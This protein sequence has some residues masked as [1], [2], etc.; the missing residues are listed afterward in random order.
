MFDGVSQAY[1]KG[2]IRWTSAAIRFSWWVVAVSA[3]L[4]LCAAAYLSQNIRIN[5]DTGGMLSSDLDFQR[6]SEELSQAFPQFSNNLVVVIDGA[7]PDAAA[8]ASLVLAMHLRKSPKKYG[9]VIDYAGSDFFRRNGFL[10]MDIDEIY[11]LSDRL[12]E[13]QPFLGALWADSSLV[14]FLGV[15]GLA[16]DE[17]LKEENAQPIEIATILDAVNGVAQAQVKGEWG[18]MSWQKLMS[19]PVNE[20]DKVKSRRRIL[21]I[22]PALK[23]SSLAPAADAMKNVRKLAIDLGLTQKNGVRV[24][25]TG[26]AALSQEELE[27]VEE[28]MGLAGVVSLILVIGLLS[29]GLCSWRLV[30]AMLVTLLM[31]LIW[32]AGF[33]IMALGTL[34]LI[35]VAFA[36]LFIGLSVDFGIHY[37]LRYNE[38]IEAGRS[39]D[40][41]LIEAAANVGGALTLC[42]ISA[43]IAFYSFLLTDYRGLAELGLIAGTGMFIALL[44]NVTLLPALLTVLPR[45]RVSI[46]GGFLFDFSAVLPFIRSHSRIICLTGL[47]AGGAAVWTLPQAVFDFDPMNLRDP[48]KESVSTISDLMADRHTNPYSVTIL[49]HNLDQARSLAVKINGLDLVDGVST[50]ADYV[51]AE[52]LE[53][54][55]V[56]SSMALFLSPSFARA[57]EANRHTLDDSKTSLAKFRVKLNALAQRFGERPEGRAADRLSQTLVRMFTLNGG[58]AGSV[59]EDFEAR[60][61]RALPGR[62]FALNQA[63]KAEAVTLNNLP[64]EIRDNQI[65]TD[66]RAKLEVFAKED[67]RDQDALARF[68]AAV[69]TISPRASGS[70]VTILEAGNTVIRAIWEA[71]IISVT[72]IFMILLVV[73]KRLSSAILVLIPLA[74]A[75]VLTVAASTV[76][77][78]S[79][80]FAN[81]IVLPLLFGIGAAGG[82]HLVMRQREKGGEALETSTPRAILFSALTTI[83]S[84][85]SIALS[86]HPGTSSMGLLLTISIIFSLCCTLVVLPALM[87]VAGHVSSDND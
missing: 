79:F 36:V 14:G 83:G 17:T 29:I 28:G 27:S 30:T 3:L 40:D 32:T 19:G 65:A 84:F 10:Y 35:S 58:D 44:A 60:L 39:N 23:F 1:R 25:L 2:L 81:V 62:L 26:S 24:R 52:Q 80:N 21:L 87:V 85:G 50:L 22:Q 57:A 8:D 71:G 72:L 13:A 69:R 41:A 49:A 70:S 59:I 43:A 75:A 73:L 53:K 78:L 82:I 12:A 9:R 7:T 67:L 34:N 11:R 77:G 61:L 56:I 64:A 38:G 42:A 47:F 74:L 37:G 4:S 54:L 76:F 6:Y 15:L 51:P 55:Q 63:L 46:R 48:S 86:S 20:G 68:V 45:N 66:G 33:A 18:D 16:L 31:G 5:T